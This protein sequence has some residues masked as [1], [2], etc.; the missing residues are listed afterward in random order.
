MN[1]RPTTSD[2]KL[3]VLEGPNV[4]MRDQFIR[5][6]GNLGTLAVLFGCDML[7]DEHNIHAFIAPEIY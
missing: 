3:M 4:I 5:A 1:Q 6:D 7:R 2:Q